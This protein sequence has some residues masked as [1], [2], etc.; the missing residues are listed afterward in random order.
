MPSDIG[1]NRRRVWRETGQKDA[2]GRKI[3]E[4]TEYDIVEVFGNEV[5]VPSNPSTRARRNDGVAQTTQYVGVH[6]LQQSDPEIAT[7]FGGSWGG[8]RRIV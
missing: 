3:I 4:D 5:I 1:T 7:P 2:Q 8:L 6:I